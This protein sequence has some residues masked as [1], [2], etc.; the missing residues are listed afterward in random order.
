MGERTCCLLFTRDHDEA[1]EEQLRDTL[2]TLAHRGLGY[3][4]AG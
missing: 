4:A 3:H 2:T 1:E